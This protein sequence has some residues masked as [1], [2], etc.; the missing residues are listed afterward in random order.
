MT[1]VACGATGCRREDDLTLI[2]T[3]YGPRVLCPKH[4]D[5]VAIHSTVEGDETGGQ[6]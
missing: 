2:E 1:V 5:E 6:R 4:R 3:G